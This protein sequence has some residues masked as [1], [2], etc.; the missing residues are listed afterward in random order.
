MIEAMEQEGTIQEM[1]YFVFDKTLQTMSQWKEKGYELP[2][3]SSNFSRITL[4]NPSALASVLAISSRYPEVPQN[5]VEME[6]TETAGDFENNT[7]AE[8]IERFGGYGF[9]FSLDDF[10]SSYSNISMLT[11][12]H[13]RSIKLD[14]SMI[15]NISENSMTRMLVRDIVKLCNSS[16]MVCIAEGVE[17]QEQEKALLENGC[18]YAQGYYYDRPMPLRE[19]EQKYLQA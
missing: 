2:R 12:L 13:F 17:N 1:D 5:L 14:R 19:F 18:V 8:L 3:I 10:G 16:G 4:L 7:F 11:N 15:R 9:Q 6:I